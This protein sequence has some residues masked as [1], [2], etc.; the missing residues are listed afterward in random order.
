M[1]KTG[2]EIDVSNKDAGF[3]GATISGKRS[4]ELSSDALYSYNGIGSN[5]SY[6]YK[7][8]F[9]VFRNEPHKSFFGDFK[10]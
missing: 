4:W 1:R 7:T 2:D 6:G 5:T 3:Y 9:P 10:Q 8:F